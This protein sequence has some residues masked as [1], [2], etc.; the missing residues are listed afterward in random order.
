MLGGL[1][2]Y[3]ESELDPAVQAEILLESSRNEARVA[4]LELLL[5]VGFGLVYGFESDPF[6]AVAL[7]ALATVLP[8]LIDAQLRGSAA[9]RLLGMGPRPASAA[10]PKPK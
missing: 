7:F 4:I 3:G 8:L 1:F 2:R 6:R 10:P 5:A 9:R